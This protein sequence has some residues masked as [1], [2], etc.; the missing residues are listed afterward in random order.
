MHRHRPRK[1]GQPASPPRAPPQ[2]HAPA[3]E[4]PR[5]RPGELPALP[6][7]PSSPHQP[8]H[9]LH[10]P[11]DPPC[12]A[13]QLLRG[14]HAHW[15]PRALLLTPSPE[16]AHNALADAPDSRTHRPALAAIARPPPAA[17]APLP[18]A[19]PPPPPAAAAQEPAP[20]SLEGG[21]APATPLRVQAGSPTRTSACLFHSCPRTGFKAHLCVIGLFYVSPSAPVHARVTR[22]IYV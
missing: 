12:P 14:L 10:L 18:T 9:Q 5:A 20:A 19:R 4:R 17:P 8:V 13:Y 7:T 11:P 6:A 2:P 1:E 15:A 21:R 3:R 22:L 16:P